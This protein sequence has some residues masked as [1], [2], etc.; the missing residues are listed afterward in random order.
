MAS[1]LI[2]NINP[3][4]KNKEVS[5]PNHKSGGDKVFQPKNQNVFTLS[6][7]RGGSVV[8]TDNG[9]ISN[10]LLCYVQNRM[11]IFP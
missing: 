4:N 2:D 3:Q 8:M 7:K 11:D 9:V 1:N 10:D 5:T 6:D